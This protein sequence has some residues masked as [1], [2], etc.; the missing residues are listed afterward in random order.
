M[1]KKAASALLIGIMALSIPTVMYGQQAGY[2]TPDQAAQQLVSLSKS[3]PD[4]TMIHDLAVTPGGNKVVMLEVGKEVTAKTKKIPAVFV[5]ADLSGTRPLAVEGALELA[6]HLLKNK[7]IYEAKTWYIVACGNPDA[8]KRFFSKPLYAISANDL[9]RND[10][11]DDQTDEDGPDDLNND[12]VISMMR[13]KDPLGTYVVVDEDPRLMRKADSKKGE[14]G[15]YKLYT[16]GIDNDGDGEYNEDGKGGTNPAINFPPLFKYFKGEAGLYPGSTPESY[17]IMA[18]VFSH[19]EIAMIYSLDGSNLTY[20]NFR[21]DRR[22]TGSTTSIKVPENRAAMLGLDPEQTYTLKEITDILKE[23]FGVP[24]IDESMVSSF[25]GLGA[26][27]NPL[28]E[29]MALYKKY[30]DDYKEFLKEKGLPTD[31]FDAEQ[32]DDGS[33]ELWAYLHVGVPVFSSDLWIVPKAPKEK[34]AEDAL[35]PDKIEKMSKDEFL[36]LSDEQL[37]KVMGE[38]ANAEAVS[39]IREAVDSGKFTPEQL[40]G[41]LKKKKPAKSEGKMD[42]KEAAMLNF[43]DNKLQGKGFIPWKPYK[44]PTLGDVEIGGFVPFVA[45]TPPLETVDSLL[46]AETEWITRLANDLPE[47]SIYETKVTEKGGG[48]YALEVYIANNKFMPYPTGMGKRNKQPAPAIV[49]IE[50]NGV[51]FLEGHPRTAVNEVAGNTRNKMTWLIQADRPVSLKIKLESFE[52]GND[53]KIV[54]I[55]GKS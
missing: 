5:M 11:Q 53:E 18:F 32:P 4:V 8:A 33:F 14:S 13:V 48:V 54:K 55:G 43:S 17:A 46:M 6:D 10:D 45:T 12:G 42:E 51:T 7:E 19:P 44:H 25:L 28:D 27:V 39:R 37:M 52:A 41:M 20:T 22:S 16:E 3:H 29:D 2:H 24:D 31:R 1:I 26:V 30:T 23:R 49:L 38:E 21:T 35:S 50:G 9:P 15:V 36:A 47:L 40:A 34:E